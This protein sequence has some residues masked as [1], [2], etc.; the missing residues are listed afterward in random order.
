MLQERQELNEIKQSSKIIQT[1]VYWQRKSVGKS[2]R[3]NRLDV[4]SES[5]NN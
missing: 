4:E 3:I 1:K 5:I 2:I